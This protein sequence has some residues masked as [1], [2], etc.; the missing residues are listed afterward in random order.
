[1]VKQTKD[2]KCSRCGGSGTEPL[3]MHLLSTLECVPPG[4]TWAGPIAKKL[5]QKPAAISNRLA[6]LRRLGFVEATRD[7]KR[8][9]YVRVK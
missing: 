4:G 3:S 5:K 9:I 8:L 1:M 6:E 7:G 2:V